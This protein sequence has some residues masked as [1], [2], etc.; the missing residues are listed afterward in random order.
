MLDTPLTENNI[1]ANINSG[2]VFVLD[3]DR[4]VDNILAY[5]KDNYK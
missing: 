5:K 1:S 3:I 2:Y 4:Y